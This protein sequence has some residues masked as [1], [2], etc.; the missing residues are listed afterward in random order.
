MSLQTFD[1]NLLRVLEALID[2]RSVTRAAQRLGRTQ[3][4]SVQE[5]L[6]LTAKSLF[7]QD[8][9]DPRVD[10]GMF[11][12]S[13]PDRLNLAIL[14]PLLERIRKSAPAMDVQIITAARS[15]A[16]RLLDTEA[17]DVGLGWVA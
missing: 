7:H 6:A 8:G 2:E 10:R 4:A 5:V 17:V 13:M 1:L 3:R 15:E 16:I 12:I 11:R 9:F 14:P